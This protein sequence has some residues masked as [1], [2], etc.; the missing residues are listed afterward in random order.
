MEWR[1]CEVRGWSGED[2]RSGGG[3]EGG[4]GRG[5]SGGCEGRGWSG[6]DVRSGGGV[7]RM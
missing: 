3:V 1:G 7:E 4:E 2:V 5:W 6:E